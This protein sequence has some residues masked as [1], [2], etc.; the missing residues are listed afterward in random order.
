MVFHGCQQGYE[1]INTTYVEFTGY[2][3][4]AENNDIIIIYPQ[5]KSSANN[6]Y[7]CWDFW[8]YSSVSRTLEYATKQGVIMKGMHT[9][10]E[11]ISNGSLPLKSVN[12]SGP[13]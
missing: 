7:G 9:I 2:N 13:V 1:F 10:F 3:H 11:Q 6:S 8:G 4:V 5:I 12:I